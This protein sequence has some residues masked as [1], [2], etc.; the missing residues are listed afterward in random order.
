MGENQGSA[1][2]CWKMLQKSMTNMGE[3]AINIP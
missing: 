3:N 2:K 1:E